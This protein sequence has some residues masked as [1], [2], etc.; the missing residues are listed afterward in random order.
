MV[1]RNMNWLPAIKTMLETPEVEFIL[2]GT[3]HLAG[4]DGLLTLLNAG[5]YASEGL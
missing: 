5:G 2:V 1:R 3:A 4:D